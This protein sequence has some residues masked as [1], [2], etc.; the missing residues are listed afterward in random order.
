MTL[1]FFI[2]IKLLTI[3]KLFTIK[4]NLIRKYVIFVSMKFFVLTLSFVIIQSFLGQAPNNDCSSATI[5]CGNQITLA[6]NIGAS[7]DACSGCS[8]GASVAGNFCFNLDNT[9]WFTFTTNEIGG[10]VSVSFSNINCT[11]DPAYD[12]ELQ[13]VI[14]EALTPCD[15]SSYTAVSNCV[16]NSSSDFSL[17]G[18]SLSPSTTYYV[19]VDGDLNGGGVTMPSECFFNVETSGPG[20]DYIVN[21]GSDVAIES[22]ESTELEGLAPDGFVWSPPNYLSST[23]SLT[24]TS[25]PEETTTYFLSLTTPDGCTY[26]DDVVVSVFEPISVPN[27]LTPN[28][29]GFNDVWKIGRIENFPGA[30]VIVY[31][32]WGQQVFKTIGYTNSKRWDGSNNGKRLPSGTYFYSIDLKSGSKN[33]LFIGPITIIH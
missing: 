15:E 26:Q 27:T 6:N 19:L 28:N 32:R 2:N 23:S 33:N 24:P 9:T 31:D 25:N 3:I 4:I 18:T 20:V 12:N 5:L 22:G 14:I 30:E 17:A 13:G 11:N 8:D 1:F 10:D 21:A 16:S 7:V 29:D